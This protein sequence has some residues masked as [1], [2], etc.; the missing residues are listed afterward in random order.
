MCST[1][2]AVFKIEDFVDS[3]TIQWQTTGQDENVNTGTC[4]LLLQQGTAD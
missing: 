3:W 2:A 4:I 1:F